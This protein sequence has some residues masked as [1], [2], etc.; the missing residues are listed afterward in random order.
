MKQLNPEPIKQVESNSINGRYRP[1]FFD[2]EAFNLSSVDINSVFY[3]TEEDDPELTL[4]KED[5]SFVYLREDKLRTIDAYDLDGE[6]IEFSDFLDHFSIGI[7]SLNLFKSGKYLSR[8]FRPV[9]HGGFYNGLDININENHSLAETDGISLIS[10]KLAHSLGWSD[11]KPNMSCQFTCFYEAGLVKGHA[12]VSDRISSDVVVYGQDNIKSE[13]SFTNGLKYVAV[14]PVKLST[15]LRLDIQSMLNLWGMFGVEQFL[16]WANIGIENFKENLMSGKLAD[17][18]DNFESISPSDYDKENWVLRKAIYHK[19]DYTLYP[20]L[21][22]SA[23]SMFKNGMVTYA[24][25]SNG[26]PS[27][28]IP[29]PN[30]KRAYLRIDLRDHDE[31]GNFTVSVK[32]NEVNVDKYGNAWFSDVDIERKLIVIG[33]ADQDDNLAIVP[34][35]KG[36][37]VLYRSPNQQGEYIIVDITSDDGVI[38]SSDS[39]RIVG[40]VA[41]KK[42]F[43][44]KK[45]K[46]VKIKRTNPL[47]VNLIRNTSKMFLPYTTSNLIKAY[48]AI[49]KNATS[50]GYAANTEMI[51]SSIG[52]TNKSK[53]KRLSKKYKWDLEK[54]IDATVKDG[55]SA[56]SEMN[57]IR[58]FLNEVIDNRIA[59]PSALTHRLPKKKRDKVTLHKAHPLDQLLD[60]IKTLIDQADLEIIGRGSVGRG[61]R[62]AGI[63]D[64][65][66]TPV[67]ELGRMNVDNPM[68]DVGM[69][70]KSSYNKSMAIGLTSATDEI[71]RRSVISTVQ[72]KLLSKMSVFTEDERVQ[73]SL[74]WAYNIYK[75]Q[76]RSM[77]DSLLW[78][79]DIGD[80]TGAANSTIQMLA[81]LGEGDQIR[82]NGAIERYREVIDLKL[83]D[84]C[85]RVWSKEAL[86][87]DSFTDTQELLVSE[88]IAV[89]GDVTVSIGDECNI[90]DG[91]YQIRSIANSR[92]KKDAAKILGNSL[93]IYISAV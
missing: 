45:V 17:M 20:G 87:A 61:N 47:L 21:L 6:H 49:S 19:I 63:I 78:I 93:S 51:L 9:K 48:T 43:T 54:I 75:S 29:V 30:G 11:A 85:I 66:Q 52:I 36:K 91:V 15:S 89:I 7:K 44:S 2:L 14:E 23:W 90:V 84:N 82:K 58:T 92:S 80:L 41:Q 53:F 42:V 69:K 71:S 38:D 76:D 31:Y 10:L 18:L 13:I 25:K 39:N 67:V 40:N 55:T 68:V 79:G 4:L 73:I 72:E 35:D 70:L 34:V 12:V 60:A 33:G 86:S 57:T 88:G 77:H 32:P 81:N 24:E 5:F 16:E 37:A 46:P 1:M 65:L 22:R 28:R 26:N 62:I 3:N 56:D 74:A 59:L 8:V 64:S 83:E 27:I 50:I